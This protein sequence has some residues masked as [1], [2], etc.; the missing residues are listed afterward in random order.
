MQDFDGDDCAAEARRAA[1]A[2]NDFGRGSVR[3]RR[4]APANDEADPV[5]N[6]MTVATTID[7]ADTNTGG[8]AAFFT[9]SYTILFAAMLLA[10]FI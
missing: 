6:F 7:S 10:I 3:R 8:G 4:Q 9:M 2:I 1:M 5:F